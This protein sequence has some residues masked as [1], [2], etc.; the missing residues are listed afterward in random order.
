MAGSAK[1][2]QAPDEGDERRAVGLGAAERLA[3]LDK[4]HG[5]RGMLQGA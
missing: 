4:H 3:D 2:H 5:E 1:E